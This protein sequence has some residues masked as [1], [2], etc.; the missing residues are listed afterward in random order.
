MM[1]RMGKN[2][3]A[4]L[5]PRPHG[6]LSEPARARM[7]AKVR[8]GDDAEVN[9]SGPFMLPATR[10]SVGV[11]ALGGVL[12]VLGRGPTWEAAFAD[13]SLRMRPKASEATS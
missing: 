4:N 3:P 12:E 10:Y 9:D 5:A 11:R 6:C 8:W 7:L 2:R 13:A 1:R